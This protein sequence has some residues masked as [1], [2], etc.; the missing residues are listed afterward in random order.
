[1]QCVG[2][3]LALQTFS[4]VYSALQMVTQLTK[5]KFLLLFI[6]VQATEPELLWERKV[7]SILKDC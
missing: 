7:E 3:T 2:V 6:P 5:T 1:M 4:G